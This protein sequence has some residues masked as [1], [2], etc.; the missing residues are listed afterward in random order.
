MPKN[1]HSAA[2]LL[3]AYSIGRKLRTL[4]A[5]R[6]LTLSR[7][8]AETDLST[9]LLS[10]LETERAPSG[11]ARCQRSCWRKSWHCLR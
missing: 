6:H 10:K 7:L 8:A 4:R 1:P 3:E 11:A 9:A 2:Q 5:Q